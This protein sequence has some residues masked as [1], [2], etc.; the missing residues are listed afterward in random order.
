MPAYES[1]I[2]TYKILMQS[3]SDTFHN[4][5]AEY[6]Y[7]FQDGAALDYM[8]E[9]A[10]HITFDCWF[11]KNRY[12]EH[13][14][15]L[16]H[17]RSGDIYELTHPE[18]GTIQGRIKSPSVRHD[19]RK[20]LAI[21]RI[22]FIEQVIGEEISRD[23][24]IVNAVETSFIRGQQENQDA[25][26]A[27]FTKASGA[28]SKEVLTVDVDTSKSLLSQ[29]TTVSAKTRSLLADIDRMKGVLD[30]WLF[31][32][33]TPVDAL[34]N[35]VDYGT[36]L[37]GYVIG[38]VAAAVEK[39]VTAKRK[40]TTAP[41]RFTAS[42]KTELTALKL[43]VNNISENESGCTMLAHAIDISGALSA[44]LTV[45]NMYSDDDDNRLEF[46]KNIA[47]DAF[48]YSGRMVADIDP[49]EIFNVNELENS[50]Y[51]VREMIQAAYN[52]DRENLISLKDLA[53][54]LARYVSMVK[55]QRDRIVV[56]DTGT[57][58]IPIHRLCVDNGLPYRYL[59]LVM[60]INDIRNPTFAEGEV[61]IYERP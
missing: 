48:D 15:F 51:L 34:I 4:A 24:N 52:W 40:V 61:N 32:V 11:F 55:L 29:F 57:T 17:I 43:S 10:R 28:D 13:H 50:L 20:N 56:V 8:G 45:G 5:I 58:M 37:P 1:K 7:P 19:D 26:A 44:G 60:A 46:E 25:F 22:E 36:T 47:I 31:L 14:D 2:D 38:S 16:A 53:E 42:L 23:I 27:E 6:S 41:G 12:A 39:I 33:T 59:D 9:N 35:V 30:N 21:I 49:I 54:E 18:Y 3:I